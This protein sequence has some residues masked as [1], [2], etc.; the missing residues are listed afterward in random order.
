L[1]EIQLVANEEGKPLGINIDRNQ[2]THPKWTQFVWWLERKFA[3][4]GVRYAL[5]N[6]SITGY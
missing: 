3:E 5:F 1:D 2:F 6:N 4:Y